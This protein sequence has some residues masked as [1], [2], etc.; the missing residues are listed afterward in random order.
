M[1]NISYIDFIL[2]KE[3]NRK[4]KDNIFCTGISDRE[5]INFAIKYLLGNDWYVIDPLGDS[6][7]IQI[8]LEEILKKYS[9]KFKKELKDYS[10]K[11]GIRKWQVKN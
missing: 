5:F 3:K 1:T 4:D 2:E 10:K 11:G 7:I 9:K 8:A 6:Q